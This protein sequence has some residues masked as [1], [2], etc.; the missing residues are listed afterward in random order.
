MVSMVVVFLANTAALS[1]VLLKENIKFAIGNLYFQRE[2][3]KYW[4]V[5][6]GIKPNIQQ[7]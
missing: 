5:S 6:S 3:M 7:T 1:N 4:T 2:G